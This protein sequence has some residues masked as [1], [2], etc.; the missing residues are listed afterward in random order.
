MLK[1]TIQRV[2]YGLI[3][4]F[5][6][7]IITFFLIRL[8]PGSPFKDDKLDSKQIAILQEKYGLK[9]PMPVQFFR[10]MGG[11]LR[12]DFGKSFKYDNQDVMKDLVIPRLPRTVKVGLLS[13]LI[14]VTIGVLLGS[15][16]ALMRGTIV[17]NLVTIAAVLGT[18]IPSFVF[19]MLMQ[20]YF[21]VKLKWFPVL[22][23]DAIPSSIVVPALALSV[24]SISSLSRFVRTELV[25]VLSS[26]YIQL[27]RAKGLSSSQVI[28]RHAI[29]NALIPVVT[30][31]GPM[32]LAVITGG[33]VM[34]S[35]FGIPGVGDLLIKSIVE[36]DYFITMGVSIVYSFIFIVVVFIIDLLYGVIDPRIRLTG[37]K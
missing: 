25:E 2:L 13:L 21:A 29:R 17:D 24:Y 27:A 30:I 19:A 16:A 5:L 32:V 23:S 3:T 10:Y 18:S 36:N 35:I 8:L 7:A 4:L 28:F 33:V 22:Y 34:E 26:D 14:G 1:Y 31:L 20:Y 9:D 6:I 12:L 11:I 15:I 37:G